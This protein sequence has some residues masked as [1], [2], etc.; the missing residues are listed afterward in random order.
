L[1]RPPTPPKPSRTRP[2]VAR[3]PP[4]T[5]T[6]TDPENGVP[7]VTFSPSLVD[8]DDKPTEEQPKTAKP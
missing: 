7:R 6:P 1:N 8:T 3:P 2:A 4:S 5:V